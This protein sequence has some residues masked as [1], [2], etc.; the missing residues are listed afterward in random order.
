MHIHIHCPNCMHPYEVAA[1]FAGRRVRC[2]H[3]NADFDVPCPADSPI[4][5]PNPSDADPDD[6]WPQLGDSID[7]TGPSTPQPPDDDLPGQPSV[8]DPDPYASHPD[9]TFASGLLRLLLPARSLA[10]WVT[11]IYLFL[12]VL[13]V[14]FL[15]QVWCFGGILRIFMAS[16]ISSFLFNL[17]GATAAG[18]DY[19]PEIG[20]L[21]DDLGS[22]ASEIF[23]PFLRIVGSVIY[24]LIPAFLAAFVHTIMVGPGAASVPS[25]PSETILQMLVGLGILL[26]PMVVLVLA[27]GNTRQLLRPDLI[28]RD[29]FAAFGP[30]LLCCLVVAGAVALLYNADTI[31]DYATELFPSTV[32]HVAYTALPYLLFTYLAVYAMRLVGLF[33][34][35]YQ[36]RLPSLGAAP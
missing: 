7:Q 9:S 29:I 28:V 11:F 10:E 23:N 26:W 6:I 36:H 22:F 27:L 1:Q 12:L 33:C 19:L 32:S 8:T 35:H 17:V 3:C 25:G 2:R 15:S 5:P 14:P 30:Y 18:A 4:P 16:Y 31:R 20:S 13:A 24:V 21:L 34:R